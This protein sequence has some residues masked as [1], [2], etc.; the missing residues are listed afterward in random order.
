[1]ILLIGC[2]YSIEKSELTF[3]FGMMS[4]KRAQ[5]RFWRRTPDK[6]TERAGGLIMSCGGGGEEEVPFARLN[7][8]LLL[9]T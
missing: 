8:Q 5:T 9:A 6:A 2:K 7:V 4:G 1:V 3:H